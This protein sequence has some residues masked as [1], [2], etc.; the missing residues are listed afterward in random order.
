MAP[1][2][3]HRTGEPDASGGRVCPSCAR[4]FGPEV[5]VCVA[6][7]IYIST[8]R[9]IVTA[10]PL[11]EAN[12]RRH[13]RNI[14]EV[15]SWFVPV[16]LYPI[17]S[18]AYGGRRPVAVWALV[19]MTILA[20]F[21]FWS[22]KLTDSGMTV[23]KQAMLWSG[24]YPPSAEHVALFYTITENGNLAAYKRELYRLENDPAIQ[25]S[26]EL[27]AT[28]YANLPL[29]DRPI[30]EFRWHQ[31]ISH[32]FLHGD[33]FHL[34]GNLLFLIIIGVKVNALVGNVVSAVSYL[35]LAV[36][37]GAAE[38]IASLASEPM[39]MV[40]ASGAVMGMAGMY[41]VLFPIQR[42]HMT[43]WIRIPILLMKIFRTR[44]FVVVLFYMAFDVAYLALSWETNVAHWAHLGGFCAGVLLGLTL[45]M[46]RQ[47]DARG[48]D[49][50]S[51][52][53][54]QLAWQWIGTPRERKQPSFLSQLP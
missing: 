46:T 37:A 4:H 30:G 36:L 20:S 2:P 12:V 40:G 25:S 54:G 48:G 28:A 39:P 3:S 22:A 53:F 17:G 33:L 49:I 24:S 21:A 16:G 13:T 10:A 11:D 41:L 1:A 14:L 31:L 38:C 5:R 47:V 9:A 18:E 23:A 51:A 32:A 8:G 19:G 29:V 26:A 42:V 35:L 6:C 45:L 50:L 43:A 15:A 27:F 52:I 7:G 34:A 44:G